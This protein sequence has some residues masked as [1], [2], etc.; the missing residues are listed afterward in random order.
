M[1]I[2]RPE[3]EAAFSKAGLDRFTKRVQRWLRR[4]ASADVAKL[5]AHTS[6]HEAIV[7]WIDISRRTGLLTEKQMYLFCQ[8]SLR[9]ATEGCHLFE[10]ESFKSI[11]ADHDS[12]AEDR[13]QRIYWSVFGR[14]A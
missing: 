8:A 9:L 4:D 1:F 3:H 14:K 6:L 13:A 2:L 7:F 10:E 11:I 5:E 12:T